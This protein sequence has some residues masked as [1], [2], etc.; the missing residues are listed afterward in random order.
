[1]PVDESTACKIADMNSDGN[2]N[3]ADV[4]AIVNDILGL[5]PSKP[6]LSAPTQPVTVRLQTSQNRYRP[7]CHSNEHRGQWA[8]SWPSARS[9]ADYAGAVCVASAT[10]YLP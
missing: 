7:A 1:M 5:S 3:I 2:L 8:Y 10:R 6:I 9:V 4:I